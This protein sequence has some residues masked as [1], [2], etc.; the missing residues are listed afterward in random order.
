MKKLVIGLGLLSSAALSFALDGVASYNWDALIYGISGSTPSGVLNVQWTGQESPYFG[1]TAFRVVIWDSGVSYPV[2]SD[3][4]M[5]S[6]SLTNYSRNYNVMPGHTV[7]VELY[8]AANQPANDKNPSHDI[9]TR[10]WVSPVNT[11]TVPVVL[12]TPQLY[13]TSIPN[14]PLSGNYL[15]L[16]SL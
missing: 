3:L 4:I 7:R 9:V 10:V 13:N 8:A 5:A 12:Y 6:D 16:R 11:S 1:R 15:L 2:I 14:N